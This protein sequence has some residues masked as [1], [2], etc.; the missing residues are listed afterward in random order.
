MATANDMLADAT[1]GHQIYLQRYGGGVARKIIA[2]LNRVDADLYRQ[3]TEAL[4]RLPREAFTVQ[5]LDQLLVGV[6]RLNADAYRVAGEELDT[7]LLELAGYEA[8]WQH[9]AIQSALPT[10]VAEKLSLNTITA[11]QAH[12]AAMATPFRGTLLREALAGI[13]TKR[14]ERIRDAVRMGFVE[15]QTVEQI[16]RRLRGTRSARYS[17]GLLE[18]DRRGAE[19]LIRTAVNHVS[20]FA[21]QAVY[22]A[23]PDLVSEVQ[24]ISTLDSKTS[25]VCR[26]RDLQV[27]PVGSGPR[28]P[29]HWGC[30]STTVPVLRSAWEALGLAKNEIPESTRSSMDGQVAGDMGYQQWL[31]SKPA[32]VQDDILGPARGKL[33]RDGGLTLDKFV[34]RN[35]RQL[36]LRELRKKDADAFKRAGL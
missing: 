19:A 31:K 33:F 2:L 3:L 9:R 28:P 10:V 21:R 6:Q 13:E 23:N 5:R 32:D 30:R 16:V 35:G 18:V 29:A 24:W 26:A 36:T 1:I 15:G 25:S 27:F 34:D 22:D 17:D 7:A 12:A 11:T 20:N 8:S 4:E 14:A